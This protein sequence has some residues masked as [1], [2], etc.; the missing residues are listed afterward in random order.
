MWYVWEW[1]R[2]AIKAPMVDG[3]D[4]EYSHY[5]D[6]ARARERSAPKPKPNKAPIVVKLKVDSSVRAKVQDQGNQ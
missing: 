5:V 2:D 4:M 6:S 3:L 1:L